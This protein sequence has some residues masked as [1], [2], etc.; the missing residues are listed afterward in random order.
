MYDDSLVFVRAHW[1]SSLR[2]SSGLGSRMISIIGLNVFRLSSSRYNKKDPM[3]SRSFPN[4]RKHI[5]ARLANILRFHSEVICIQK[6]HELTAR[7]S[8][9]ISV[10]YGRKFGGGK[11]LL[12]SFPLLPIVLQS[13]IARFSPNKL[14]THVASRL[15]TSGDLS[16]R[17][18][19]STIGT[20]PEM[21][22]RKR[23]LITCGIL[24]RGSWW[25]AQPADGLYKLGWLSFYALPYR[26]LIPAKP[27]RWLGSANAPKMC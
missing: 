10:P 9:N 4:A 11:D 14:R 17:L 23:S 18:R 19:L 26:R 1:R 16:L 25:W 15:P 6:V 22:A 7:L 27:W 3:S 21:T 12:P 8:C 13:S 20:V 2:C 24:S 5:D